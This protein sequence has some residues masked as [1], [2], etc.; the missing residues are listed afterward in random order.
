MSLLQYPILNA[1]VDENCDNITYQAS[2]SY[3][4][5]EDKETVFDEAPFICKSSAIPVPSNGWS[6]PRAKKYWSGPFL[7]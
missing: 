7:D 4:V 2:Q 1:T 6:R 3:A 5:D